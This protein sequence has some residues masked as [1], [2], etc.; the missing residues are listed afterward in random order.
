MTAR[1]LVPLVGQFV[2][3]FINYLRIFGGLQLNMTCVIGHSLGA[4]V[5]GLAGKIIE[6]GQLGSIV[7]LDPASPLFSKDKP[8]ERLA[9]TDAEY[10]ET[11][12]TNRGM[13]GFSQPIG[14]AA[15]YPNWGSKQPGC[16]RDLSGA[17]SHTRSVLFFEESIMRPD[18]RWF[19]A[20][21]CNSYDEIVDKRCGDNGSGSVALGG[22]PLL[23]GHIK[24]GVF[25]VETDEQTPFGLASDN[26]NN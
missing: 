10:V 17:C 20:M 23:T 7:G 14:D 1:N 11:V 18:G 2:G 4:H 21:R 16:G 6:D 19:R 24:E 8:R 26:D 13:N 25:Y 15:F 22:E 3:R 12:H 9:N 5:A